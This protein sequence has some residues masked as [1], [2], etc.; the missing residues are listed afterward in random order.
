MDKRFVNIKEGKD[1][2]GCDWREDYKENKLN[3][4]EKTNMVLNIIC[5]NKDRSEIN[6]DKDIEIKQY[7]SFSEFLADVEE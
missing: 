7:D 2:R 1:Y 6:I 4:N 5:K 3:C